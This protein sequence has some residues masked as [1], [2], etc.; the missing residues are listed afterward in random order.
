VLDEVGARFVTTSPD[1]SPAETLDLEAFAAARAAGEG[2][3]LVAD[4]LSMEGFMSDLVGLQPPPV[5]VS[6]RGYCE[7]SGFVARGRA[8]V[9]AASDDLA[10]PTQHLYEQPGD[11]LF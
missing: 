3:G 10:M 9:V 2:E 1:E 8:F 7:W 11:A 5:D 4:Y 6:Y